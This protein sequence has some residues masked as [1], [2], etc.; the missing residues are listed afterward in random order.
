MGV[1]LMVGKPAREEGTNTS[2]VTML[3][4]ERTHCFC[5]GGLMGTRTQ[6][7]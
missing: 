7:I 4:I 1:K 2:A 6:I 3:K 5:L